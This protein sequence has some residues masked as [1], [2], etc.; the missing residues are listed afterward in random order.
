MGF[1]ACG[2]QYQNKNE[3]ENDFMPIID[4]HVHLYPEEVNR[5]PAG[6]AA[7][8]G[9]A[10]WARLCM[11]RRK[12]GRPVQAFPAVDDLLRAMDQAGVA[13]S[14]LLGWYWEQ[15]GSCRMQNRFYAECVRRYGDRLSAFA[16][17]HPAM[18]VDG[19]LGELWLA[20]DAGLIGVGELSPHSVGWA[21]DDP[22]LQAVLTRAGEW[23][24]PVNLHVTEPVARDY[25]GRVE[26]PLEDFVKL[27]RAHPRTTFILAHWGGRLPLVL[28]GE[29]PENIC[30]DTAASPLLYPQTFWREFCARVPAER[31]LFGSD[32]PLN[33]YPS[34]DAQPNMTR[35]VAEVH[36]SELP[37]AALR[38]IVS[39][40]A[41]RLLGQDAVGKPGSAGDRPA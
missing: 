40:N 21:T 3:N 37:A 17:V 9:E 13:R 16:T 4:A 19:A 5:D 23:G 7:A 18:G 38:A 25:P 30:Y 6:W 39:E 12:D 8:C 41:R 24:L 20:R 2:S 32:Y 14:V 36:R 33:L 11:R 28:D 34:I 1:P 29:V 10:H 27:A 22:V 26:T 15:A 31:V 35:L